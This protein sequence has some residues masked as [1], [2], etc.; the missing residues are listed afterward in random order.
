MAKGL[1]IQIEGA[2]ALIRGLTAL[3]GVV[4]QIVGEEIE[5]GVQD[6]RTDAVMFA[7]VDTGRLKASIEAEASG[8]YGEVKTDVGYAGHMEFGTGGEVDVREGW[9]D[10][11][12]QYRGQGKRTVNIAPRPF[13]RPALEKNAPKIIERINDR[14]GKE[15]E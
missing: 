15:L 10:I 6:I 4:E 9:E 2:S 3:S 5:A 12:E 7:P 8:L 11:A 14:I 1:N 13:M